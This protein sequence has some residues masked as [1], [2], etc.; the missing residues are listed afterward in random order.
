LVASRPIVQAYLGRIFSQRSG[1]LRGHLHAGRPINHRGKG[2]RRAKGDRCQRHL[3]DRRVLQ[4][5]LDKLLA[6]QVRPYRLRSSGRRRGGHP[7]ARLMGCRKRGFPRA[8]VDKERQEISC[9]RA[10]LWHSAAQKLSGGFSELSPVP[11]STNRVGAL[12]YLFRGHQFL[13]GDASGLPQLPKR[14]LNPGLRGGWY[15]PSSSEIE[16]CRLAGLGLISLALKLVPVEEQPVTSTIV[17]ASTT[18]I[19]GDCLI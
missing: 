15:E 13:V 16:G 8:R 18:A 19:S 4:I 14:S 3:P 5:D 12:F 17:A 1:P 10:L 6:G 7:E 11:R 2:R 9:V